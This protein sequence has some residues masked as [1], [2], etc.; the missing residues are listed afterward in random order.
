MRPLSWSSR[1]WSE[2]A[3]FER[4]HWSEWE[5]PRK[6]SVT[7]GGERSWIEC[8]WNE[9]E[10]QGKFGGLT[11]IRAIA[12]TCVPRFLV[13]EVIELV[14][15]KER[16]LKLQSETQ[17]GRAYILYTGRAPAARPVDW[18]RGFFF[19]GT[20]TFTPTCI[21][22]LFQ[23]VLWLFADS[24]LQT[25]NH[26]IPSSA[27][28]SSLTLNYPHAHLTLNLLPKTVKNKQ[29]TRWMAFKF[30]KHPQGHW[31]G[32]LPTHYKKGHFWLLKHKICFTM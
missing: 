14:V 12:H 32:C 30:H 2:A 24:T 3:H 6:W 8:R 21:R 27:Q 10:I 29:Q 22:P 16:K 17:L 28:C 5:F 20:V 15:N 9:Q 31:A 1:R 19:P 4:L 13:F 23:G 7:G 11:A 26:C 18:R 25:S